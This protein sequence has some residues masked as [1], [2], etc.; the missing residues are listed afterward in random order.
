MV[1]DR[2]VAEPVA[3]LSPAQRHELEEAHRRA[4][5]IRRAATVAAFNGWSMAI[6]AVLS[7]PFAIGSF[8]GLVI[9][10]GLGVLAWNELRGR[11]QLLEFDAEAPAILGWNQL[12]LLAMV[13]G[14]CL[15]QVICYWVG[16]SAIAAEIAA[17]PELREL[18][19][20]G[21]EFETL[22]RLFVLMFYSVVI[23]LSIAAQGLN[24]WYYFSRR[25]HVEAYVRETPPWVIELQRLAGRA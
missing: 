12:A 6:L 5:P 16:G 25:K 3:A 1:A 15:W 18:L 7:A 2:P 17:K 19:G 20:K 13:C 4:K 24:A 10:V 9:A 21:E 14:Y 11:R 23:V 8:V 22:L